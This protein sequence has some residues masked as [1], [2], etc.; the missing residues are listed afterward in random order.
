M[1]TIGIDL[2]TTNSVVTHYDPEQAAA[3]ILANSEGHNLTPSVVGARQREGSEQQLL[4]GSAALNWAE[5]QPQDVVRS[6]K[7]LM[8]RDFADPAVTDARARLS[9]EVV[10]G[11][12]DD[13]RAHVVIAG[14]TYAPSEVSSLI[15]KQLKQDATW[16]LNEE[17]THAVITVPAYFLDTQRAATREAGKLAGLVVKKIID[18]PTAAAVAYGLR[19]PR[20]EHHRVLVYDLG[21]GTF[22]ISILHVVKDKDGHDHF[23][24]LDYD[25]DSWLGGDDFDLAIVDRIID[26]VK[27]HCGVDPSQDKTFLF[28]AKV[29]AET[30]KRTL[31]KMPSADIVMGALPWPGDTGRKFDVDMTMTR[32]EYNALIEP[33]VEKTMEL[34][35]VALRRKNLSAADI[36]DVLLVGGSTLTPKVYQAVESFFGKEKV[37]RKINPMEC[38]ALGAGILAGTLHG[39]DCPACKKTNDDAANNCAQCGQSLVQERKSS[40]APRL[41]PVTGMALGI[42]AVRGSRRD[43]F[44]PI[45]PRGTPRPLPKPLTRSFKAADG[46]RIRVPVYQGDDP[47]AS[48][49]AEQG[50]VEYEL[51]EE[52]DLNSR[53]D[54][55][56]DY[57][58]D[59]IV[60][61]T[62]SVP[63][64]GEAKQ[65]ALRADTP[66]TH[67]PASAQDDDEDAGSQRDHLAYAE[68]VTRRFLRQYEQYIE[69]TQVMKIRRD[70]DQAEQALIFSDSKEC[71][72]MTNVL[73]R[74]I[75]D[76]GLASQL[77]VAEQTANGAAPEVSREINHAIS[78]LQQSFHQG[79]RDQVE[80]QARFLRLMVAKAR[81][82]RAAVIRDAEDYGYALIL[83]DE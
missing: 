19:L 62:I 38:V 12:N 7:R 9:Y 16:T 52:I 78:T 34:V 17:V 4:V 80:E 14:G 27:D 40:D 28:H 65:E 35:Q 2:G 20:G 67:P 57:D 6:V 21:G 29:A 54:V 50:V 10:P 51:P 37:R 5:K 70:L 43:V 60:T 39:V 68:K 66:R 82:E 53:V 77:Y 1:T 81:E 73:Y 24:V 30:A 83:D 3:A 15:L 49:N 8:G 33:L 25:G 59:G 63:S 48:R 58:S 76:S 42:A 11:P 61:V 26:W 46:R 71:E 44:V 56:F 64:I 79:R 23:Q 55:T 69:P 45:I 72:R 18:E 31:S 74:Y 22:D 13:P 36:S 32:D 75:Y 47:V 41:Y